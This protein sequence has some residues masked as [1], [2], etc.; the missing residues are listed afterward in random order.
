MKKAIL[1]GS[2]G[3]LA[4]TSHLQRHAFN[5]AFA[6]AGLD[7]HWDEHTYHGLLKRSGGKQ[8]IEAYAQSVGMNVDAAQ[9]HARKSALFQE[10]LSD[11]ELPLRP[12]VQSMLVEA[13]ARRIP[14]AL[15]TC[16]SRSNIGG[17]LQAT[18]LSEGTFACIV[19]RSIIQEAKPAPDAFTKALELLE[20][21]AS[22]AVAIEDNP[23]GARAA[24]DAGLACVVTAGAA[25]QESLFPPEAIMT[26]LVTFEQ[27]GMASN[28]Q[29]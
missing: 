4:E 8:R 27:L 12:G 13:Q 16:T 22:D 24:L 20:L 15:A 6:E 26:S 29:S 1:F 25:H 23:D 19:D 5:G 2:I 3:T 10:A 11:T 7:W 21:N 18:G 17:I 14:V 9:L 28:T